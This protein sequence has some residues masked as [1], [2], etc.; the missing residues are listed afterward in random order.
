M[1]IIHSLIIGILVEYLIFQFKHCFEILV[2][3]F[4]AIINDFTLLYHL[5]QRHLISTINLSPN[6]SLII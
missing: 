6:P 5:A 3:V 1:K 2:C 4:K